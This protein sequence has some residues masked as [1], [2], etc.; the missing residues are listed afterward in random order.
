MSSD[1]WFHATGGNIS[2]SR[3]I[4]HFPPPP[5]LSASL[6]DLLAVDGLQ[7]PVQRR[8]KRIGWWCALGRGEFWEKASDLG[9]KGSIS[10]APPGGLSAPVESKGGSAPTPWRLRAGLSIAVTRESSIKL[11][12]LLLCWKLRVCRGI[13]VSAASLGRAWFC[14]GCD[15]VVVGFTV[16]WWG[17]LC[18]GFSCF[19]SVVFR[20]SLISIFEN[21]FLQCVEFGLCWLEST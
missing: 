8:R 5:P 4:K 19:L 9:F 14:R 18:R 6:S 17:I 3:R 16:R 20:G 2:V 10:G 15:R 12:V 7:A 1:R 21:L 13:S 11:W